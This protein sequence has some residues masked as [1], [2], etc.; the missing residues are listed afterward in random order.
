[1][2]CF[3]IVWL[4]N[5]GISAWNA[6]AVGRAWVETKVAGGWPRFMA[7][8]GAI[9]SATGFSWCYLFLLILGANYLGKLSDEATEAAMMLG[10]VVIIPGMLFSG[11]MIML[12]SWRRAFR[13]GGIL[14]YGV[15]AYNTYAQIHNTMSAIN[16]CPH[17]HPQYHPVLRR[18]RPGKPQQQRR[19]QQEPG[20]AAGNRARGT[21]PSGRRAHDDD[22]HPP[23]GRQR[24]AAVAA[25]DPG[26]GPR[27]VVIASPA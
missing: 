11:L 26:A 3:I 8:M 24:S 6:Y 25:R 1:M 2:A 21:G 14:N 22:H 5:F 12:D 4:L 9:M 13:N 17:G 23:D 16:T 20:N 7:W 19:R 10:Y 18:R 15:A 27:A